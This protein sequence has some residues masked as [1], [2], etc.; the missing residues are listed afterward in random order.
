M[1]ML[2]KASVSS[3]PSPSSALYLRGFSGSGCGWPFMDTA[4]ARTLATLPVRLRSALTQAIR[5]RG[6][7]RRERW[8]RW[9]ERDPESERGCGDPAVRVVLTL[10]ESV[11][12]RGAIG[13]ELGAY[14]HELGAGVD[15]LRALDLRVELQHPRFAPAAAD[16]A[17]AQLRDRLE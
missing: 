1:S 7:V 2:A 11:A 10:R 14:G 13:P 12:D 6:Q 5:A 4:L 3:A 8:C 15:D 9:N 17:V 16:R